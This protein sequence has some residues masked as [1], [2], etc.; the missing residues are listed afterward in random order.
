MK[1]IVV[2]TA[3][4]R[5]SLPV[6]T[7][8]ISDGHAT[9]TPIHGIHHSV[10][11]AAM[12]VARVLAASGDDVA[13]AV[14]LGEDYAAAV[15]DTEAYRF[16]M[17][18]HL[19]RRELRHTPRSVDLHD[20]DGHRHVYLDLAHAHSLPIDMRSLDTD[21]QR[22][23]VVV[24]TSLDQAP[25]LPAALAVRGLRC[26]VDLQ[27]FNPFDAL[28]VPTAHRGTHPADALLA[29]RETIRGALSAEILAFRADAVRARERQALAALASRARSRLVI[30]WCGTDGVLLLERGSCGWPAEAVHVPGC[31]ELD[32]PHG[33]D[34]FLAAFLHRVI[35]RELAPEEAARGALAATA[36]VLRVDHD[37]DRTRLARLLEDERSVRDQGEVPLS[38]VPAPAGSTLAEGA[39]RERDGTA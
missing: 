22:A 38:P 4:Q 35:A 30:L 24:I 29:T 31:P 17:S 7:F 36:R 33:G 18:T 10:G 28:H 26:A 39:P 13:L 21:A 19:C 9:P 25:T 2:G 15:I 8:P 6:G 34:T 12:A 37:L 16:D 32:A 1:A 23:D 5:T 27:A 20:E 3:D 14:P 11:G